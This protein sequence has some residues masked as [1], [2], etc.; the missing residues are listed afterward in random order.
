MAAV[1]DLRRSDARAATAARRGQGGRGHGRGVR[2]AGRG[3]TE[4]RRFRA[5]AG[6]GISPTGQQGPTTTTQTGVIATVHNG[7]GFLVVVYPRL[8]NERQAV[9]TPVADGKGVKI[10]SSGNRLRV[11]QSAAV[12]IPRRRTGLRGNSGAD[13]DGSGRSL[14]GP[15]CGRTDWRRR[16]RAR[17][18]EVVWPAGLR[19]VRSRKPNVRE[20]QH[21]GTCGP[22]NKLTRSPVCGLP[23]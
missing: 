22:T 7:D 14:P 15:R 13:P 18:V 6:S 8:K 11:P 1:A 4:R 12:H 3:G 19:R 20:S 16:S 9:V 10:D 5:R 17:V 2:D 23:P 21:E